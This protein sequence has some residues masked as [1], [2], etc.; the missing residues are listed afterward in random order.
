MLLAQILRWFWILVKV[1]CSVA[2][3]IQISVSVFYQIYPKKTVAE[4]VPRKLK[5]IDFPVAFK[6][7][8]RPGFN[9]TELSKVGYDS[10]FGYFTGRS[11]FENKAIG[12]GNYGW[13]GHTG[14]K[15]VFSNASDVQ[16]RIFQNY[17]SVIKRTGIIT[18]KAPFGSIPSTS[19]KLAKPNYPNNCLTLDIT[20][21]HNPEDKLFGLEIVFETKSFASDVDV[22]I[23][24]RLTMVGRTVMSSKRKQLIHFGS[25]NTTLI[26]YYFVSFDQTIYRDKEKTFCVNYPT[27]QYTSFNDCDH[28]HL[29]NLLKKSKL[30]P[31]W[32]TPQDLSRATNLTKSGGFF[33]GLHGTGYFM[34]RIPAPCVQPCT[35][36]SIKAEFQY[37]AKLAENDPTIYLVFDP[38][39]EG[40]PMLYQHSSLWRYCR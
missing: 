23:E 15:G 2:C 14:E 20:K 32:A 26:K 21:L 30:H 33:M 25:I 18:P 36:T 6:V 5:D 31:A 29:A 38:L 16:D 24:D 40:P 3:L 39:V 9:S 22:I 13:A 12:K 35:Q 4:T 17:L 10:V 19:Y 11:K 7:C 37:S 8:I 27:D 28:H 34:G 1:A